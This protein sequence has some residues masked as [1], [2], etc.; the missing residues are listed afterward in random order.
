MFWAW[1]QRSRICGACPVVGCRRGVVFFG[2]RRGLAAVLAGDLVV[3]LF[4]FF[5][6]AGRFVIGAVRRAGLAS[7]GRTASRAA[8]GAAGAGAAFGGVGRGSVAARDSRGAAGVGSAHVR[9]GS[10]PAGGRQ[11]ARAR[12]AGA[13][14]R[15]WGRGGL[16]RIRW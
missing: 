13:E 6:V 1:R 5:V 9:V 16:P 3:F 10:G 14:R 2:L 11:R 7:P 4:V 8:A 12:R 15:E